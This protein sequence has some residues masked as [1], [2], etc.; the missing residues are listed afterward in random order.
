MQKKELRSLKR[1]NATPLMVKLAKDNMLPEPKE[2]ATYWGRKEKR[3]TRYDMFI[4][5]QSRG[6]LLMVAL[7]FPGDLR[8]GTITPA[9]EVYLNPEGDEFV[10][11]VLADGKEVKWS[12][13]KICNLPRVKEETDYGSS[14]YCA[15]PYTERLARIWQNPE[16]QKT[17]K[18]MLGVDKGGIAGIEKWQDKARDVQ[19]AAAEKKEQAPWD[20]DMALVPE[21][22]KGFKRFTE[23]DARPEHFI[24]YDYNRKGATSGYCTYCEKDV[25]ITKPK[26]N[27]KV[28]CKCCRKEV[29]L[30]S[31]GKIKTLDT[32]HYTTECIQK[33]EGGFV[34]RTFRTRI[35]WYNCTPDKPTVYIA[36]DARELCFENGITKR[37]EMGMYKNKIHRWIPTG[38]SYWWG[39]A[40]L[41]KRNISALKKSVLKRSAFDL[42]ETLPCPLAKYL[43]VEAGNPAIEMLAKLG[44][45]CLAKEMIEWPYQRKLLKEDATE[46]SKMLQLDKARLGRL[47]AMDGGIHCLKWLQEE[48]RR[49]TIWPD[50][51]I[52]EMGNAKLEYD[53][54]DFIPKPIRYVHVWNYLRKQAAVANEDMQQTWSGWRDYM[55]MIEKAK[56]NM[57]SEQIIYPKDLK[58]AHTEVVLFLQ[59]NNMKEQAKKLAKK[60]PKVNKVLPGIS[61]FEYTHGD[62]QIVAPKDI[63]DIVK[64]GTALS[65]CVHTCDFYFDR[66]SKNETY[67]F[68]LRKSNAPDTPWYTLE[69]EPSGNIR[70]KRT[71]GDNQLKDVDK[72]YAFLKRW[73]REFK[74]RLTP[75]EIELGILADAAR[76]EEYKKLRT[77]GNRVWHG[78]LAGQLLADVLEADF[79]AVE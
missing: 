76:I 62:Y 18:Q 73:Q 72:A 43:K 60:W 37:Y 15:V 2:Y 51:M 9:Y 46:L 40:K 25:P 22:M 12:D 50:E 13:A 53:D 44:M 59:G 79:M 23:H 75:E 66:I 10:T 61:K 30:K 71:T 78:K 48:K 6:K 67:L 24:F 52:K 34:I 35:S 20:A 17:I 32:E 57:D 49:D 21:V 31:K 42:W 3:T 56:W 68:F 11:R 65:H 63:L 26:H 70:Q 39:G 28:K 36:E 47:R 8:A 69:V 16:G 45:F 33:I 41:Y 77:D 58:A 27:A 54:F 38:N 64:E 55:D 1:I 5:C 14:W 7:F 4:R 74:K 29:Q 19:I